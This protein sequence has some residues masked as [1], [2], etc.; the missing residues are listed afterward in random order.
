MLALGPVKTPLIPI[1]FPEF[2]GSRG[3][4]GWVL[5]GTL[6]VESRLAETDSCSS[7]AQCFHQ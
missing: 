4:G 2:L 5:P 6:D 1:M 3:V 7:F